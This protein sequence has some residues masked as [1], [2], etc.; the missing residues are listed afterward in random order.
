MDK[1]LIAK[2]LNKNVE[3]ITQ[4]FDNY[5]IEVL[6]YGFCKINE[7]TGWLD[8]MVEIEDESG[9]GLED[10]LQLKVNLYDEEGDIIYSDSEYIYEDEFDGFDTVHF[11]LSEDGLA[12]NADRCRLYMTKA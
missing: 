11:H 9:F 8:L 10:D 12:F 2:N 4:S 6:S 3:V 7:E 1:N 5:G